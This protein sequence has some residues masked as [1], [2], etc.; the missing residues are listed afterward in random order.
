MRKVSVALFRRH[1]WISFALC[2]VLLVQIDS[3]AL[4]ANSPSLIRQLLNDPANIE[5]NLR[6][7]DEAERRGELRKALQAYERLVANHPDDASLRRKLLRVKRL[8]RP[9]VTLAYVSIGA[10]YATNPRQRS[11]AEPREETGIFSAHAI[12]YDERTI[13][14]TRWRSYASAQTHYY[15]E[16]DDLTSGRIS[17]A[18]GPLIDLGRKL[19]LHVA[20]EVAYRWLDGQRLYTEGAINL[21]LKGLHKG[22][23]QSATLRIGYRDVNSEFSDSSGIAI[24]LT[25]RFVANDKVKKGDALFFVP[26]FRYSE[27][28]GDESDLLLSSAV[29]PG[30]FYETGARLAYFVPLFGN[31][32]IGAGI[33]AY[34]RHYDQ[35]VLFDTKDREDIFIE[36]TAHLILHHPAGTEVDLRVD[37]R[38]EKNDSN[39][40]AEDFENHVVGVRTLRRF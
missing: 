3:F 1:L 17:F 27:P 40:S 10:A 36:P 25:G 16:A 29:F 32:Q 26:R 39:D 13:K 2:G 34:Y 18:T 11:S 38:F 9:A 21:S 20:P 4:A 37:Y 6:Y 31:L 8:L 12:L 35:N 19:K 15:D 5:L 14:R 33:G 22:T 23:I 24:D 30:N 28:T 7:A